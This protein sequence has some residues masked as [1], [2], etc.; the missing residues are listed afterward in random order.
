MQVG[1][2]MK[3]PIAKGVIGVKIAKN[4][5]EDTPRKRPIDVLNGI[6]NI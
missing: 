6:F 4:E 1:L 5:I 3:A 2:P